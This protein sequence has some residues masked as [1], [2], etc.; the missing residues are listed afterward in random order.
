[1]T[2]DEF[3]ARERTSAAAYAAM[4]EDMNRKYFV[5]PEADTGKISIY[6]DRPNDR[7]FPIS[8]AELHTLYCNERVPHWTGRTV[9]EVWLHDPKRRTYKAGITRSLDGRWSPVDPSEWS[10]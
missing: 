2:D 10:S 9:D 8:K 6:A 4:I 7:C 1:M 5:A 3:E